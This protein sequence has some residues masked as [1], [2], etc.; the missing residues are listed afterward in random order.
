MCQYVGP[1]SRTEAQGL[2]SHI[3]SLEARIRQLSAVEI[4]SGTSSPAAPSAQRQSTPVPA[5]DQA[6][7]QLVPQDSYA[8]TM[9]VSPEQGTSYRD[10]THWQAVLEEVDRPVL[11]YNNLAA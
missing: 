7:E 4:L 11:R 10:P 8:G 5:Q 9:L 6:D 2:Q 1:M 3:H